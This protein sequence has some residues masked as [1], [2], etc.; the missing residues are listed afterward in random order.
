[1]SNQERTRRYERGQLVKI[2][3]CPQNHPEHVGQVGTV[4]PNQRM[5]A[6]VRVYV[7]TGICQAKEVEAVNEGLPQEET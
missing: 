2:I 7:G 3:N 1:M 5:S 6:T 4:S